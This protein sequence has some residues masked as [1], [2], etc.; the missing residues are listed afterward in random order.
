MA[1]IDARRETVQGLF[2]AF[3]LDGNGSVGLQELLQIVSSSK[4]STSAADKR[5]H[6]IIRLLE[7]EVRQA[8]ETNRKVGGA[9]SFVALRTGGNVIFAAADGEPSLD[10]AAFTNF[11]L[12]ITKDVS[13]DEFNAFIEAAKEAVTEAYDRTQGSAFRARV[14]SVFQ[15]LDV[16]QDGFVDLD[17]LE[18]LLNVETKSD[19]KAMSRWR[20][21]LTQRHLDATGSVSSAANSSPPS[22]DVSPESTVNTMAS[23]LNTASTAVARLTLSDFQQ[24]VK[25]FTD[26]NEDR[27]ATILENVRAAMQAEYNKY[28]Q[29]N[30][31]NDILDAV[32]EDLIRERPY[33]VLEGIIRSCQRMQRTGAY[34]RGLQRVQSS[35]IIKAP[36]ARSGTGSP[37]QAS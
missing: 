2:S 22:R 3:D 24:F 8:A 32:L 28:L 36:S 26:G 15:L 6:K 14:W 13:E 30:K 5:N 18:L 31:V 33:D 23:T 9:M 37:A 11:L 20:H 16:N 12:S 35:V 34:R 29:Q 21:V 27:V 17:E 25:E 4:E 1:T 10:P 19:R 7:A